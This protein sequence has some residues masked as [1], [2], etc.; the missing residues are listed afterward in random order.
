MRKVIVL[1][2]ASAFGLGIAQAGKDLKNIKA[3]KPM[4][5]DGI[6]RQ[7]PAGQ[8][9]A[10]IP[11]LDRATALTWVA[12]DSTANALGQANSAI[13]PISYA[14]G[15]NAL[16]V[17][18]RG[19]AP[20][21]AASGQ[22]WYNISYDAGATWR[23]VGELNGGAPLDCRYPSGAISNPAGNNDTSQCLFVYAAP[24]LQNA[25]GFGQITYGVDFPLGG[26][27]G[28]G[29]VDA[30]TNNYTS[31]TTIWTQPSSPWIIWATNVSA[32]PNDH[33]NWRTSD[34]VSVP[35][36]A[37]PGWVD[38][39]PNFINSL[40][41]LSG[42][43]T[44][45]GSYYSVSGLFSPDS[46]ANAFNGGYSKSVDNGATWG[47]WIRPQPDWMLATGLP[48]RYDL[49][50]YVQPA[51]GTVQYNQDIAIDANNRVHFYHVVVDT[52]WTATDPR[53][54]L[55][56]YETGTG[57]ASKWV[58]SGLSLNP[59]TGI[60]YPGASTPASPY[61]QQTGN[62]I[63]ASVSA[64]GQVL[65][66][67]WLDAATSA[68]GD[69][70]P[71]IWFSYRRIDGANWSTP[72]NL[73]QTPG[74]PELLL[75]AAPIVKSNGANS[76]TIFLGRTYQA[77][78][79]T[80]PPDYNVKSTFFVSS[81]TFIATPSGVG[82]PDG[83]PASFTLEQNYPNPFN[84]NTIIRYS[85]AQAGRVSLKVFNTLGQEVATLVDGIVSAGEYQANFDANRFSSGVYIYKMTSGAK[86][87]SRKMLLLR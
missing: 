19:A 51:G 65:T 7:V 24:N 26:G 82:E 48:P 83:Q 17:L 27:A 87:E 85:V 63:H 20:Y 60:G 25:G 29:T 45:T 2:L 43:A 79:N 32:S 56:V 74:F 44:S 67:V 69:T 35:R 50:D 86:V 6:E 39:E 12:V 71:D 34:Y 18:H 31:S 61:L 68:P 84:P 28:S 70:L 15:P 8:G 16:V 59:R 58:T 36:T 57:W 47:P 53:G 14:S 40:G 66:M 55:E 9:G 73:T 38:G 33:Q 76:Y 46:L 41:H 10:Y 37:P 80:Y 52:P 81:H 75:H 30:G 1:F 77:N 4:I 49:Y 54:I 11:G 62:A 22:L 3:A 21:A 72:A 5:D 23:R 42:I 78:I 13:T 64:D